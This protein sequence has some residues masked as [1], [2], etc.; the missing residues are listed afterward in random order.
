MKRN[1]VTELDQHGRPVVGVFEEL[2]SAFMRQALVSAFYLVSLAAGLHCHEFFACSPLVNFC[3]IVCGFFLASAAWLAAFLV[4]GLVAGNFDFA[5]FVF[6]LVFRHDFRTAAGI[7]F[8][9]LPVA[10]IVVRAA[11][12]ILVSSLSRKYVF[13]VSLALA[14]MAAADIC[15]YASLLRRT[16]EYVFCFALG[17]MIYRLFFRSSVRSAS[18]RESEIADKESEIYENNYTN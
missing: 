16:E 7:V 10:R 14:F 6:A 13:C 8:L 12:K 1:I 5:G 2:A 3:G 9:F 17:G 11:D 15:R 18:D 4:S